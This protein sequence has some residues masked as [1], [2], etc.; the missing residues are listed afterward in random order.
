MTKRK[1]V[2]VW[3]VC[4]IIAAVNCHRVA[5]SLSVVRS[6]PSVSPDVPAAGIDAETSGDWEK[7][8]TIYR[9]V[10]E[11]EPARFDLWMRIA[12]IHSRR[13]ELPAAIAALEKAASASGSSDL[14]FK[15]AQAN[16]VANQAEAAFRAVD[17]ALQGDPQNPEY[18]RAR[19]QLA[20]WIGRPRLAADSYRRLVAI[21]P[22]DDEALLNLARADA[23]SGNLDDAVRHYKRYLGDHRSEKAIWIEY[24]NAQIW[25][26]NF[27]SARSIIRQYREMFGEDRAFRKTLADIV[28]RA[29]RPRKALAMTR[30]LLLDEPEDYPVLFS[31]VIAL[32]YDSRP[33]AALEK[34]LQL[35]A[36][37]PESRENHELERFVRTPLRADIR[38]APYGYYSDS[39]DLRSV[40]SQL[41]AGVNL[42]REFRLRGGLDFGTLEAAA[43]SG[44]EAVDGSSRISWQRPWI[45]GTLV[46]APAVTV[47]ATAAWQHVSGLDDC[48]TGSVFAWMRPSD[49]LRFKL[50]V[51]RDVLEVS[52]RAL[53]LGIRRD[54]ARLGL[55]WEPGWR[56]VLEVEADLGH[57]SDGNRR[58][59]AILAPRWKLLRLAAFNF[60]LGLR[61]WWFG[62]ESKK[63]NGYWDPGSFRSYMVVAYGYWKISDNDGVSAVAGSGAVGDETTS[64]LRFGSSID[65]EGTFGI[66]RDFMLKVH[67]AVYHNLRQ[68]SG[69]FNAVGL[70]FQL[71]YRF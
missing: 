19:A 60:D 64:R 26:G 70:S 16:S 49:V 45:G 71:V 46:L 27:A 34:I 41:E 37:R 47:G 14:Y 30:K 52:P 51:A 18:L 48:L 42:S 5:P 24:V 2:F 61:G 11:R 53:S 31:E 68:A 67:A 39:D 23:W 40:S 13:G 56:T 25:R 44:F 58:W 12:D 66:Y 32:K 35:E 69:A 15:L 28:A 20:N 62:Y 55:T 17:K 54:A 50:S 29:D 22:D 65:V 6:A 36:L 38:L 3:L 59:E 33:R 43:G 4:V 8:L 21:L 57:Y 9:E 1:I 10:L 63:Q 7:A